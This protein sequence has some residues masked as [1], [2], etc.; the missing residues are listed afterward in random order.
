MILRTP[1]DRQ[2][3]II[4]LRSDRV[5][6]RALR[7]LGNGA[8]REDLVDAAAQALLATDP[9]QLRHRDVE[10]A[11]DGAF[12]GV[13]RPAVQRGIY[14]FH[15]LHELADE[16]LFFDGDRLTARPERLLDYA[17]LIAEVEPA[18]LIGS[19]LAERLDTGEVTPASLDALVEVQCP[20]GMPRHDAGRLHVDNHVHLG[21]VTSV[22]HALMGFAMGRAGAVS[23]W[24]LPKTFRAVFETHLERPMPALAGAFRMLFASI[25]RWVMAGAEPGAAQPWRE[26]A[27]GLGP[28]LDRGLADDGPAPLSF[29][30]IAEMEGAWPGEVGRS[31]L[32]MAARRAVRGDWSGAFLLVATL[33]CRL[34]LR[35]PMSA[36]APRL[37]L[38]GFVHLMHA[39]RDAM[40]MHGLGL[41]SFVEYFNSRARTLQADQFRRLRWMIGHHEFRADIKTTWVDRAG[42]RHYATESSG[43]ART[44]HQDSHPW[45]RYHLSYHFVRKAPGRGALADERLRFQA[46]RLEIRQEALRLRRRLAIPEFQETAA[47]V[48]GRQVCQEMTSRVRSFDVAGNENDEPIELFAPALR[49]LREKP[50]I[51]LDRGERLAGR[52]SLSIHAG[53]DFDHIVGGLRHLDETVRFCNMG[54]GDRVGHALALGLQP[55]AWAERQ[56]RAFVPL[57]THFD[58]LVWLWH[59]ATTLS[60]GLAAA[61]G[62]LPGLERR[63]AYYA[64]RLGLSDRDPEIHHRAWGWRRNCA[65]A[66][67]LWAD[68]PSLSDARY[69]VPDARTATDS[70]DPAHREFMDYLYQRRPNRAQRIT[71]LLGEDGPPEDERDCFS[72]HDLDFVEALQDQLMTEYDARGIVIEACPSSNVFIGRIADLAEHP[73]LRWHPPHPDLLG[74]GGPFNRFGLRKGPVRLCLN[75]DDPGVFPTTIAT[76]HRLVAHAARERFALS[77]WDVETWIDRLRLVGIAVFD[78]AHAEIR[79]RPASWPGMLPGRDR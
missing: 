1:L 70:R 41:D 3:R 55:R 16:F 76:E 58:N 13:G 2:A 36:R 59:H 32:T 4:L 46:R 21:G 42:L 30:A 27:D 57:E 66:L 50:L 68:S 23:G 10:A 37:A 54:P 56:G 78:Q 26:L 74:P 48:A 39:L 19:L 63:I 71:V 49:W 75:T 52:R 34:D 8:E 29:H 64:G 35:T 60:R 5:L 22:G 61:G 7:A 28:V 73:C 47:M 18:L 33:V 31:L 38:I 17:A 20:L 9:M 67:G 40:I 65:I 6:M 62:V 45:Q 14:R 11:L 53:E 72:P 25:A 43:A 12:G 44:E 79:Y 69:W 24:A 51:Q 15:A 77:Q